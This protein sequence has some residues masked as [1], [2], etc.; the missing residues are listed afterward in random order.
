MQNTR[1]IVFN[2]K[3]ISMPKIKYTPEELD[4]KSKI[5]E[6]ILQFIVDANVN[7]YDFD[8]DDDCCDDCSYDCDRECSCHEFPGYDDYLASLI[9][10]FIYNNFTIQE[11]PN[12]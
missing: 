1:I 11:A 6:I 5:R 10:R 2:P 12:E 3:D 7:D 9:Q 4:N 8:D